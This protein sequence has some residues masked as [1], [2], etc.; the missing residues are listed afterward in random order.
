MSG[1]TLSM[2]INNKM[3]KAMN[4]FGNELARSV[5]EMLASKYGFDVDEAMST[6]NV[7][8]PRVDKRERATREARPSSRVSTRSS[9]APSML[10]IPFCGKSVDGW[11]SGIRPN[12]GLYTQ[13]SN[14]PDGD[15]PYCTT[16]KRQASKNEHG[17]P[18]GGDIGERIAKGS[19]WRCPKGKAPIR[20]ANM[21]KKTGKEL[22]EELRSEITEAAASFGWTIPDDEWIVKSA[23]RGR[24]RKTK[25]AVVD[26][27]ATED[28]GEKS[29]SSPSKQKRK[30]KKSNSGSELEQASDSSDGEE[31]V[32]ATPSKS[33][34]MK[35]RSVS[36]PSPKVGNSI[37]PIEAKESGSI[38]PIVEKSPKTKVN[39]VRKPKMT[40]EEKE[41][42]KVA[43][44]EEKRKAKEAE[45]AAKLAEKEAA[46]A[47]KAA[48]KLAEKEAAKAAKLAQK[49]AAKAAK[50][51][52]KRKAK[53]AEKAAKA[54]E[55]QKAK[56]ADAE[57]KRKAKEAE[58][59]AKAAEKQKTK[60]TDAEEKQ[61]AT[62]AE[63]ESNETLKGTELD[64]AL[65]GSPSPS[66][67]EK[68]A[69]KR[70]AHK[71]ANGER[72]S[73]PSEG[74]GNALCAKHSTPEPTA[75]VDPEHDVYEAETENES[76]DDE[77]DDEDAAGVEEFEHKG[78]KYLRDPSTNDIFDHTVFM[79]TG[80]A[81]EIGVYN[82]D[83]DTINFH[84]EDDE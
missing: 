19:E 29:S 53:E 8:T 41:A 42:A 40:P 66:P 57:E 12:G 47:A 73:T 5:I 13:C 51:E 67:V 58:K 43:K 36:P 26:T 1:E 2:S 21:L 32:L 3:E 52:E 30:V 76:S 17:L 64:K 69:P 55:K 83:T 16:C 80:E 33:T 65:F 45:K 68:G 75:P 48:A 44:A 77:S 35:R 61:K 84:D 20:L 9:V 28:E 4:L 72:C 63:K 38:S 25:T 71:D 15:S 18:N 6:L 56:E 22:T 54:A 31:L 74:D 50:A 24:P 79:E 70:C 23:S 27:T 59:A 82:P 78:K 37:S 7:V 81:E 60:E 10:P 62:K 39:K 11:C 34:I 49:E 14:E 46:K